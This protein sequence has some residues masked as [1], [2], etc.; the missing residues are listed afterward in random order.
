MEENHRPQSVWQVLW[1]ASE[2]R[3]FQ[4]WN[5]GAT[6]L[7]IIFAVLTIEWHSITHTYTH[8]SNTQL[9]LARYSIIIWTIMAILIDI[10]S[11]I[12]EH[13]SV[14]GRNTVIRCA[15]PDTSKTLTILWNVTNYLP[16]DTVSHPT[17]LHSSPTLLW[18]TQTRCSGICTHFFVFKVPP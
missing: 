11:K 15:D 14:M 18:E 16:N 10:N 17:G 8:V 12:C 7:I 3:I 2:P 5:G 13:Q 6:N 4:I 1:P 9:H